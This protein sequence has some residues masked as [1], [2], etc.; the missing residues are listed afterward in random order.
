MHVHGHK[1]ALPY[2]HRLT[3]T[4]GACTHKH[5]VRTR[6]SCRNAYTCGCTRAC[7]NTNTHAQTR[8]EDRRADEEANGEQSG[9]L[10][11]P[12]APAASTLA[13]SCRARSASARNCAIFSP[14]LGSVV[15]ACKAAGQACP[16]AG[17]AASWLGPSRIRIPPICC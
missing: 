10:G 9:Y 14:P 3:Q 11:G 17:A 2:K 4:D 16:A 12:R 8:T 7:A 5:A 15:K 6:I 13:C 1:N